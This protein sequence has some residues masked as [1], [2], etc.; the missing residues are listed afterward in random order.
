VAQLAER[1]LGKEQVE[2]SNP[3]RGWKNATAAT[4]VAPPIGDPVRVSLL[5]SIQYMGWTM[6]VSATTVR[7][8]RHTLAELERFQKALHTKTADETIREVLK[9]QRSAVIQRLS[10]SLRG[11]L[12]RFREADRVDS[13]R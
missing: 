10:G 1:L 2:G 6:S 12:S 8:S 9:L 4:L 13:D 5:C 11:R 7:V 3:S